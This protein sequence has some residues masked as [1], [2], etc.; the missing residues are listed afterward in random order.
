MPQL[1]QLGLFF[2]AVVVVCGGVL[3]PKPSP[4]KKTVL[5]AIAIGA[6][7]L[8]S[9]A[10]ADWVALAVSPSTG[11]AGAVYKANSRSVAES[12][13]LARCR[14][15]PGQPTDCSIVTTA[16][17]GWCVSMAQAPDARDGWGWSRQADIK[18]AKSD[19]LA[20]CSKQSCNV[21]FAWCSTS[22]T[23]NSVTQDKPAWRVCTCSGTKIVPVIG[24]GFQTQNLICTRGGWDNVSCS[25]VCGA[26]PC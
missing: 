4:V 5:L 17:D 23:N 22:D 11:K 1:M 24:D 14:E 10:S 21:S 15:L 8:A 13:A 9:D 20:R 19:A 25:S 18:A 26:N 6:A 2:A 3:S 12:D 16:H 7:L